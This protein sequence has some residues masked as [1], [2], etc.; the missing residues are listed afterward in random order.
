MEIVTITTENKLNNQSILTDGHYNIE[1]HGHSF[2]YEDKLYTYHSSGLARCVYRSECGKYVIKVP[3]GG[4]FEDEED[5]TPTY[6]EEIEKEKCLSL[7]STSP[8]NLF[9]VV[10]LNIAYRAIPLISYPTKTTLWYL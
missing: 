10:P 5:I 2:K 3:I 7:P 1:K 8:I 9:S 4:H 6:F